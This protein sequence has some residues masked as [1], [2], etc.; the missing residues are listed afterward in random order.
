MGALT[1]AEP[2]A[3]RAEVRVEDECENL[4]DSLLDDTVQDR[5]NTP[6]KL[7]FMPIR[8][9]DGLRSPTRSTRS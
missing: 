3:V 7:H 2:I 6:G 5:R 8:L 1:V 9:W 4:R